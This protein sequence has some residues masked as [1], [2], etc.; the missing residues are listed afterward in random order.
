[1]HKAH[2]RCATD[3]CR[4]TLSCAPVLFLAQ[5]EGF[6][7]ESHSPYAEYGSFAILKNNLLSALKR[8]IVGSKDAVYKLCI[9]GGK[10]SSVGVQNAHNYAFVRRAKIAPATYAHVLH[11]QIVLVMNSIFSE[12]TS[13]KHHLYT[14]STQPIITIYLNKRV[15]E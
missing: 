12:L 1:M 7:S 6:F 5:K 8:I 15:E 4:N 2:N 13:L 9:D 10:V 14:L 11:K 3:L